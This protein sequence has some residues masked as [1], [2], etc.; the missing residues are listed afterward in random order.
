M[1]SKENVATLPAALALAELTLL[2]QTWRELVKRLAV[3]AAITI[4]VAVMYLLVTLGLHGEAS[5]IG[6]GVLGRLA[7]HYAYAKTSIMDVVLTQCRVL[8]SYLFMTVVPTDPELM[9]PEVLSR[10]LIDPPSTLFACFALIGLI[11][12]GVW[13]L[14]KKPLVSFGIGF[15]VVAL[16]PESLM[17]PQYLFFSYRALLPMA[18]LLLIVG[19]GT[20]ALL[21]K[22]GQKVPA[23]AARGALAG[24]CAAFL[25]IMGSVTLSVA[26]DWSPITFWERLAKKLPVYSE[27]LEIVPYLDISMN[28]MAVLASL[29][30]YQEAMDLFRKVANLSEPIEGTAAAREATEKFVSLFGEQT[31]R[32]AAGLIGLGVALSGGNQFAE[33][34]VPYEKALEMEPHHPDVWVSLGAIAESQGDLA[35]ATACYRK[36]LEIDPNSATGYQALGLALCKADKFLEAAGELGK[37]VQLDPANG[38][39]HSVLA[40]A[41]EQAGFF[42]EAAAVYRRS[43]EL[44]PDSAELNYSLGRALAHIGELDGALQ[45]YRRAIELNPNHAAMYADLALALDY[46]GNLPEAIEACRKSL[47]LDPSSAA[48]YNLLGLCLKKAG[49]LP[50]AI[51]A[52][53]QAISLDPGLATAYNNLGVALEKSGKPAEAI[54]QYGKSIEINPHSAICYSNLGIALKKSGQMNAALDQ[55]GKA[56]ELDSTL[57]AGYANLAVA[58]DEGADPVRAIAIY[59][60]VLQ[61]HPDSVEANLGLASALLSNRDYREAIRVCRKVV[62]LKPDMVQA[63]AK[64]AAA[65]LNTGEVAEAIVVLGQA[66]ALNEE[67]AD[68]LN[69]LGMAFAA[70]KKPQKAA[71]Q[72]RKAL[73]LEPGHGAARRNLDKLS[74]DQ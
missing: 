43:V 71:E 2:R 38:S 59:R 49:N 29:Q 47:A 63:H 39:T 45:A 8:F 20:L 66:L 14:R 5:E 28:Y 48:V 23:V 10:S 64:L 13:L 15:Y 7:E 60:T 33:A 1:L 21:E 61:A 4:P 37:A 46:A 69:S 50:E 6:K 41:L 42:P 9:R 34:V 40:A 56:L 27:Q 36:A 74:M 67:N 19:W 53:R 54:A 68:L 72:F 16:L 25:C 73:A 31:M 35:K 65:L 22:G 32:A 26:K 11:G 51:D 3:I 44:A 55:Y 70:M 18:G 30:K 52:Y 57:S 24:L 17:I 62:L 12:L 58:V